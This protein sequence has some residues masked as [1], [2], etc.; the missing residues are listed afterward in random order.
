LRPYVVEQVSR[1]K[2]VLVRDLFNNEAY[3][4]KD[5][6]ASKLLAV[7]EVMVGH[8]VRVGTKD[9]GEPPTQEASAEVGAVFSPPPAVPLYYVGGAAAQLTADIREKLLEFSA[10]YLEDLRQDQPDATWEEMVRQRSYIFNHFV[11]SLPVEAYDPN[12]LDDMILQARVALQIARQSFSSLSGHSR[13]AD[14]DDDSD[15]SSSGSDRGSSSDDNTDNSSNTETESNTGS[16]R[17]ATNDT[18]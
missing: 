3:E 11:M 14:G 10:L 17:P 1:G 6:G 8:L 7:G 18:L 2:G 5:Y 15:S 13:P 12:L 16:D 4:V 9:A